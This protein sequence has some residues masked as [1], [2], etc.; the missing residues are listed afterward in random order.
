M[1]LYLIERNYAEKVEN[2]P[3]SV[4]KIVD[5]NREEGIHWLHSF[6]SADRKKTYCLYEAADPT[7]IREAAR[8]LGIPADEIIEVSDVRPEAFIGEEAAHGRRKA[9]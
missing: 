7:D 5:L 9:P 4:G 6:L 2:D 8:R 1:P 3:E